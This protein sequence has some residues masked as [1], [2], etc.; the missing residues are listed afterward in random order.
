MKRNF[1]EPLYEKK[2]LCASVIDT[3]VC[4]EIHFPNAGRVV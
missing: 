2:K 1:Y 4:M 3:R